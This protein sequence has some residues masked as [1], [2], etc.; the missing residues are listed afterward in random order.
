MVT[1]RDGLCPVC[2]TPATIADWTPIQ[3][4]LTV[5]GCS[6]EGFFCLQESLELAIG[7]AASLGTAGAHRA[8]SGVALA[9]GRSL[10]DNRRQRHDRPHRHYFTASDPRS[11]A[12]CSGIVGAGDRPAAGAG[13]LPPR[14]CSDEDGRHAGRRP[15]PQ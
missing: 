4:W 12:A 7:Q 1:T 9:R 15:V 11:L 6:C 10:G 3:E 8:H 13:C 2:L 5:E 14:W